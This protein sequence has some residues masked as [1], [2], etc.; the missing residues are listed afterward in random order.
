MFGI[1]MQAYLEP[2]RDDFEL[3]NQHTDVGNVAS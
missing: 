2:Y 1:S 3:H